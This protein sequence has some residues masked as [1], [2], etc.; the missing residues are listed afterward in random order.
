MS[1]DG[2]SSRSEL[3]ASEGVPQ[4]GEVIASKYEVER[5]LGKGGMGVVVAARHLHLETKVAIK[6]LLPGMLESGDAA[7]RFAREARAAVKMS[8]EHIARVFDVGILES[9]APYM[10]M[11]YLDGDDLAAWIKQRGALPIEQAIEFVLQA[12][13]AVADAHALGIIHR[14]LKP[15]NLFCVRRSDGQLSIKVLDFGI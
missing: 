2:P 13:V 4:A 1:P 12:C 10:V 3:G 11:E 5:V 9:G 7:A 14:D 6:F 15:A 8:S